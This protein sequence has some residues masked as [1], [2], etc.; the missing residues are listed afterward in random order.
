MMPLFDDP[1]PWRPR[2]FR[3]VRGKKHTVACVL[4]VHV[5]AEL[6]DMKGYVAAAQFVRSLSRD[7][8][9]A[10]GVWVNPR[11]GLHEPVSES[12]IRRLVQSI[13]PL[14]LE[15]VVARY[16]RPGFPAPGRLPPPARAFAAPTAMNRTKTRP[17][18][19]STMPP[20]HPF[21]CSTSTMT[22]ASTGD[23]GD[24]RCRGPA[25]ALTQHAAGTSGS[26]LSTTLTPGREDS[27]CVG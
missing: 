17:W 2:D 12:T 14:V 15:E 19:S 25:Y 21:S 18:P 7:E 23:P 4:T 16:S 5:L 9:Q 3:R 6:P 13:D 24:L 22:A 10:V 27:V 20:A 1:V 11:T 26:G 8:L